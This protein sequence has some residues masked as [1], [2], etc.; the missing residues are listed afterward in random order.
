MFTPLAFPG[1]LAAVIWL[2]TQRSLLC[3]Q[4]AKET[5]NLVTV[6]KSIDK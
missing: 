2:A 6:I 5:S 4:A 3:D 1:N